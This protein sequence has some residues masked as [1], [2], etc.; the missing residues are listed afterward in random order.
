MECIVRDTPVYYETYGN[1]IPLLSLHGYFVDHH[2]MTGCMEPLFVQRTGWQR[3]Y[4]DLPG[5]GKT[6][7]T[8]QINSSE[9][10]LELVLDFIDAV[11]PNQP[12]A[13]AGESY[14]GLISRGVLQ[15]RFQQ[16]VGMALICPVI[17]ADYQQ[18]DLPPHT[19]IVEDPQLLASL[20]P[21]N[22]AEFG[23]MVVVQDT[24]NWER[25]RDE[26]LTGVHIANYAFLDK[27]Q[28]QGGFSFNVD[29]LEQPFPRPVILFTGRQDSI[30]G[31]RDAWNVLEN[32]SRG[33]F[34]V[35]DRAGHNAQIEQSQL[36]TALMGE[37]L[38][39]VEEAMR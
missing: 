29:Q 22:A 4:L 3:I 23:P 18:R 30:V 33:T 26:I 38:D 17:T 34:A 14:G 39:R 8:E 19:T 37:W 21:T 16:L 5:M 13:L 2:L 20:S 32:Y 28:K 7:G 24:Y 15:R 1:G 12:F 10:V 25:F 27:L 35:L 6:P 9:D 36:F 31:Y 11:I